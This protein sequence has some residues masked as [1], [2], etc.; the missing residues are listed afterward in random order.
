MEFGGARCLRSSTIWQGH[1]QS[2][3]MRPNLIPLVPAHSRADTGGFLWIPSQPG[4]LQ[5]ETLSEK[6]I[7]EGRKGE[8][9]VFTEVCVSVGLPT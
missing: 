3:H 6:I 5:S 7:K 1:D 4:L 2:E 8:F 9:C